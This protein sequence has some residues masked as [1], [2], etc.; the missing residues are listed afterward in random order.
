MKKIL[1]LALCG[2]S[3]FLLSSCKKTAEEQELDGSE[4]YFFYQTTCPHCHDA[5]KYIKEKHPDL[6]MVSRDVRMP[7]NQRLFQYAVK[8]YKLGDVAG[9]PLI[10]FDKNY[11]MGWSENKAKEFEI[12]VK[13]Y[14]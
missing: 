9:T 12:Y 11:I 10:C 3:V 4:I 2:L 5:A 6:K 8:K 7:G 1:L 14:E 13:Q